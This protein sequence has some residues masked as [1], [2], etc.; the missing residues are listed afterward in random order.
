MELNFESPVFAGPTDGTP[1]DKMRL[2][3]GIEVALGLE[4]RARNNNDNLGNDV[5]RFAGATL[6]NNLPVKRVP[7]LDATYAST[8]PLYAVNHTYLPF[9]VQAGW[10]LV[11]TGPDKAPNQHNT[12]V[13]HVD[14]RGQFGCTNRQRLG[15]VLSAVAA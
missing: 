4:A 3:T 5:T 1:F 9:F 10:Y 13:T 11:E 12:V 14:L 2:Y 7:R 6:I 8:Y 15:G